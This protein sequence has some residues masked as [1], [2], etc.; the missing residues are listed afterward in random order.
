MLLIFLGI[1]L[2]L[3][4]LGIVKGLIGLFCMKKIGELG[5]GLLVDLPKPLES[6]Q[7]TELMQRPVIYD[8]GGWPVHPDTKERTVR[9]LPKKTEFCLNI[10]FFIAY[11]LALILKLCA[12]CCCIKNYSGDEKNCFK[13]IN[14]IKF[15]EGIA[16]KDQYRPPGQK[17]DMYKENDAKE[18]EDTKYVLN[19]MRQSQISL[20]KQG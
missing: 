18:E 1:I 5:L 11:P 9:I 6:Y 16:K 4:F 7:E 8:V 14:I 15:N 2:I 13:S 17:I 3:M 20:L 12:L 19:M 10:T